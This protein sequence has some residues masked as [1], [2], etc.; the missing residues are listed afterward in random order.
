MWN[1]ILN[2]IARNENFRKHLSDRDMREVREAEPNLRT[3][4]NKSHRNFNLYQSYAQPGYTPL[5]WN[6]ET[7]ASGN[8]NVGSNK[9]VTFGRNGYEFSIKIRKELKS[10]R[11]MNLE[12]MHNTNKNT[13]NKNI[14][15]HFA[16]DNDAARI[17]QTAHRAQVRRR[18]NAFNKS[19]FSKRLPLNIKRLIQNKI[20]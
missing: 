4:F 11:I 5:N 20:N 9:K 2:R 16:S 3:K 13:W 19:V 17:I 15:Q 10:G 8:M 18:I 6:S 7:R 1:E 12:M 14:R